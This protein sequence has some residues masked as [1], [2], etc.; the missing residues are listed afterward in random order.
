[1]MMLVEDLVATRSLGDPPKI[2]A[3]PNAPLGECQSLPI[4]GGLYFA[5]DEASRVWYVGIATSLRQRHLNHE[6]TTDFNKAGVTHI[7]WMAESDEDKRRIREKE[8]VAH[9]APPLNERL[10]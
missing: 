2:D 7:A 4:A 6:R 10:H 5:V 9:F 8:L 3:L 1:M